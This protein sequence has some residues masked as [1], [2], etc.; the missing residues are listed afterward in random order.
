MWCVATTKSLC[1][2]TM[3]KCSSFSIAKHCDSKVSCSSLESNQVRVND[4]MM[5][6]NLLQYHKSMKKKQNLA[7]TNRFEWC[8]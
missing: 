1:I 3:T 8:L 2:D 6:S 4:L 5:Y 7:S